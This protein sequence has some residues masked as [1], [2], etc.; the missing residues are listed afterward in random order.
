VPQPDDFQ[1]T[2]ARVA[3]RAAGDHGFALAG[4]N[5]LAA[6]GIISRPTADVDLFADAP[7]AVGAAAGLVAEA[8]TAASSRRA[9]LTAIVLAWPHPS[10]ASAS[11]CTR[12]AATPKLSPSRRNPWLSAAS[13]SPRTPAATVPALLSP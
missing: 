5:A 4:G 13:S 1:I 7:G 8:L 6:H 9:A 10:T 11:G 2:V 3:L 12:S